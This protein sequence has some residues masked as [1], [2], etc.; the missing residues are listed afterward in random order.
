[1]YMEWF[2]LKF[3][4]QVQHFRT[5][6]GRPGLRTIKPLV[7]PEYWLLLCKPLYFVGKGTKRIYRQTHWTIHPLIKYQ[8]NKS[9]KS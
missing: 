4:L 9:L 2:K 1:M 5:N 3:K 7:K 8:R 6:I